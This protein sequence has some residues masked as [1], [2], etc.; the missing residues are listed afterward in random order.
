ML[1][2]LMLM[3]ICVGH[4]DY[5]CYFLVMAGVLAQIWAAGELLGKSTLRWDPAEVRC[6]AV[7]TSGMTAP[8]DERHVEL[9]EVS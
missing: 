2:T 9:G 8:A 6:L 4:G 7:K 1:R 5:V 3:Y